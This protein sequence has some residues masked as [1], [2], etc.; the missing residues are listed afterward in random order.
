MNESD[1][2]GKCFPLFYSS[3]YQFRQRAREEKRRE[4]RVN[5]NYF[6]FQ[7]SAARG[8]V[9]RCV[10][11]VE[12]KRGGPFESSVATTLFPLFESLAR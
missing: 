11:R 3:F 8:R 2:E 7:L 6:L 1:I 12:V 10:H 9:S 4:E 5:K